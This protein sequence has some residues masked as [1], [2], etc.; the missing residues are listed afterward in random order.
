MPRTRRPRLRVC[1]TA[2][3]GV[4]WSS[5][6]RVGDGSLGEILDVLNVGDDDQIAVVVK[7]DPLTFAPIGSDAPD[8]TVLPDREGTIY[9]GVY[10]SDAAAEADEG[11]PTQRS[12]LQRLQRAYAKDMLPMD[13]VQPYLKRKVQIARNYDVLW[14][15]TVIYCIFFVT[16]FMQR[17]VPQVYE[18]EQANIRNLTPTLEPLGWREGRPE[19]EGLL[20]VEDAWDLTLDL[21]HE[22]AVS[23]STFRTEVSRLVCCVRVQATVDGETDSIEIARFS[24][25]ADA[26]AQIAEFRAR[27]P[28]SLETVGDSIMLDPVLFSPKVDVMTLMSAVMTIGNGGLIDATLRYR[29]FRAQLYV[30]TIDYV[31]AGFEVMLMAFTV[32]WLVGE[33]RQVV[34]HWAGVGAWARQ[35]WNVIDALTVGALIA[36]VIVWILIA[37][38]PLERNTEVESSTADAMWS[39]FVNYDTYS[40]LV[41]I[42]TLL[43]MARV[44][45]F[46]DRDSKLGSFF[47][48]IQLAAVDSLHFL[49]VLSLLLIFYAMLGHYLFGEK[50]RS[51][52]S[53]TLALQTCI[54]IILGEFP[55]EDLSQAGRLVFQRWIPYFYV[56]SLVIFLNLILLN[57]FVAIILDAYAS[58]TRSQEIGDTTVFADVKSGIVERWWRVLSFLNIRSASHPTSRLM[59]NSFRSATAP[60][61]TLNDLKRVTGELEERRPRKLMQRMELG[62]RRM[63][64]KAEWD[65]AEQ[66]QREHDEA[67]GT[68][69]TFG[70]ARALRR[71]HA[72]PRT[73]SV[74]PDPRP[75]RRSRKHRRAPPSENSDT[76]ASN[77]SA[78]SSS[79]SS[80]PRSRRSDWSGSPG[81]RLRPPPVPFLPRRT[82]SSDDGTDDGESSRGSDGSGGLRGFASTTSSSSAYPVE[83]RP[84]LRA[85]Q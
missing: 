1:S 30:E 83:G 51:F 78:I 42:I 33:I 19:I 13:L 46:V 31:R 36:F 85:F 14:L 37:R 72:R 9:V 18:T 73:A 65:E 10:A 77:L 66:R 41:F 34:R 48:T 27:M 17:D 39:V 11:P 68:V 28:V 21:V 67:E 58:I 8:D 59:H 57:I 82:A 63:L 7:D 47:V 23:N 45:K 81:D 60:F 24:S 56:Y 84:R 50:V 53:R 25:Q 3:G 64:L 32:I 79:S 70:A 26:E 55:I 38:T 20:T 76:Y 12:E 75:P 2:D 15:N 44:F 69:P 16:L 74:S 43:F 80:L 61:L 5:P 35:F 54:A 4:T 49:I 52:S 71:L 6:V 40:V 29:S 22:F 62:I